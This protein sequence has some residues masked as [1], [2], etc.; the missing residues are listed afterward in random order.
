VN[1]ST[2]I[3]RP[4]LYTFH[5]VISSTKGFTIGSSPWS[6]STK[7]RRTAAGAVLSRPA[8]KR[9]FEMFD[10]ETC[11]LIADTFKDSQHGTQE[12]SIRPY[13]QRLALNTTL[14]L[15]YG[16]RMSNVYDNLLREILEVGSAISLLRSASENF[17]D[18]V[19]ILRYEPQN[20]KNQRA[21]KLCQRRDKYLEFL[22]DKVSEKIRNGTDKPCVAAAI[23][24]GEDTKLSDVELS[25]I[26]LSLVSGGFE[27][28]PATL[29]SCIGSLATKEGQ[30][31]QTLAYQD[32]KR[33]Y[34]STE[35][36]W[37]ASFSEEKVPY[38]NALVKEASRYYTASAMNLPR[39]S[40][41]PIIWDGATIPAKTMIL[42]NLQAANHDVD[43][44]GAD[45]GTFNPEPW[46]EPRQESDAPT[47]RSL[48]GLAHMSFGAGA[49]ACPGHH[50]A[51]RV[52]Y[53]A[54]VRLLTSYRIV[55]SEEEPPNTN[56][57]D[58]NQIK[59]ALVAIPRD[60]N[61]KLIPRDSKELEECLRTTMKRTDQYYVE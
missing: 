35:E 40:T 60:F 48:Q 16:I 54:L 9:Y 36:A 57:A 22:L 1:Q 3:D 55:A 5:G 20:G 42:V 23:I 31:F 15:C 56:Y 27:T 59:S 2:V 28:I 19:P 18:Y 34:T 10:L 4:K 61:V 13:I 14:T 6:E 12:I 11:S 37:V 53:T 50:V 52:I 58:Y 24:K 26:C 21:R 43:H 41:A 32:I 46:L 38:V 51:A 25:S 17:Q 44:F 8:I 39:K 7:N 29:T 47:E 49:R 30:L 33:Y 45:A